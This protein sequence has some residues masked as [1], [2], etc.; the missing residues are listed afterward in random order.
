MFIFTSLLV[1]SAWKCPLFVS[2]PSSTSVELIQLALFATLLPIDIL[3]ILLVPNSITLVVMGTIAIIAALLLF[4]HIEDRPHAF[5]LLLGGL[6]FALVA[7]C[8]IFFLQDV[9]AD[10]HP[11]MNT[12]FQ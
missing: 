9:F 3:M 5:T 11:R 4:Y 6:A 1:A 10:Q 2:K 12:V 7:S 8:E